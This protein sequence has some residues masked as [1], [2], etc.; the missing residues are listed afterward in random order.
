MENTKYILYFV[1]T[2][3]GP[4]ILMGDESPIEVIGK[5]RV[6]LEH[7]IIEDVLHVP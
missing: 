5:G 3:T 2:C 6:E 4:P 7:G 1:T